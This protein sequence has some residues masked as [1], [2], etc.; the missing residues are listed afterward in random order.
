MFIKV[1]DQEVELPDGSTIKDAIDKIQAPYS[2]GTVVCVIKGEKELEKS[3]NKYKIKTSKG[4]IIIE[5]SDEDEAKPLIDVWKAQY[6]ELED[7][8]IRWTTS[9]E[10]AVGP[11]VT[12]FKPIKDT[13]RY[14]DG[15]VILSLSGY[16]SESTHII[17]SKDDHEGTYAV[18][19][20]NKGIFAKVTGGTKIVSELEARDYII[21]VEPVIERSVF[22]DIDSVDDLNIVL[23]DGNQLFTYISI[24]PEFESPQGVEHFFSLSLDSTITVDFDSNTLL[25]FYALQG[26]E[27]PFEKEGPR[28]RGTVTIRNSGKGSGKVYIY[29]ENRVSA[30]SHSIIGKVDKGMEIIDTANEGDK[31]TVR[32]SP[33]RIMVIAKTQKEANDLLSSRGIKQIREGDTTDDAIVVTQTPRFSVEIVS[34][35]EV[36]TLGIN[37]KELV[38]L[39]LTDN[40]PDS[41]WYFKKVSKLLDSPIGQLKVHFAFPGMNL[42]MFEGEKKISSAVIP[43]NTPKEMICAGEIGITNMSRKNTGVI[44]IRLENNS[45]FGPTGEPFTGTNIVGKIISDLEILKDYKEGDI[46]Y[47]IIDDS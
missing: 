38:H 43:E 18:P 15:D 24:K 26:V 1:N 9:N 41:V 44:G 46:I 21:A 30:E 35:N 29:K 17:F 28:K 13:F 6:H 34:E 11:I 5:L 42:L 32:S 16:S 45:E 22:K 3:V 47:A 7:L 10:V 31:I 14:S 20:V 36:K 19:N 39:S 25:G 23:E 27:K 33:E 12:D 2:P 8:K 4:I 40:A 37:Q